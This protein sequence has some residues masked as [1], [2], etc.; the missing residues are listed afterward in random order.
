MVAPKLLRQNKRWLAKTS[1]YRDADKVFAGYTANTRSV[2][3]DIQTYHDVSYDS[4]SG[5]FSAQIRLD[6][7]GKPGLYYVFVWLN[8][9]RAQRPVLAAIAT[10]EAQK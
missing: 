7:K 4:E 1:E 5:S 2:F 9:S 3:D 10:V 8:D 6:Y